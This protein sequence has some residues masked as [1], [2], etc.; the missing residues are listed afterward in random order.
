VSSEAA[1]DR[2]T[3]VV[4]NALRNRSL[5][6]SL[7]AF[8]IFNVAWWANWIAVLVWAYD[9]HG[10][11]GASAVALAQLVPAALLAAPAAAMLGRLPRTRALPLGYLVQTATYLALGAS[12]SLDAPTPVVL[13]TAVLASAA[14]TLTRPVHN[15]MLPEISHTTGDL[16]VGNAAS[17]TLEAAAIVIGPLTCGL[18][19]DMWGSGGV[20]LLM[21]AAT[22]VAVAAT[23]PLARDIQAPV[24][25]VPSTQSA[26]ARVRLV[27]EDPAARVLSTLLAA[28]ST[29][30]GMIDI[31]VVVLALDLLAL[32]DSGPGVLNAAIGLGGL[33]GAAF[34][35]VLVGS[36]RLAVGLALGGLGAGIPF[37]LAGTAPA[38]GMAA[39]LLFLCGAGKAFFEVTARTLLQR[40]LPDRLLCAVFGL[41]ESII[42]AG[43]A[44]GSL[45]APLL[46]AGLGPR[47]AFAAAG[48]F[49]PAVTIVSWASLRK[50]DARA[51]VPPDV[52]ALLM[53]VPIIS[54][55]APRI[56]ERMAREAVEVAAPEGAQ[57]IVE[58]DAGDRFYVIAEGGVTV[59]RGGHTLRQLG[60]GDWFGELALLR[61]VPRTASVVSTSDVS[62]WA[63]ERNHF[64]AAVAYSPQ[65]VQTAD[66]HARERYH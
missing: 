49:L 53:R 47:G 27:V 2:R 11:R 31:L 37:V 64:L 50:L 52:L 36:Q 43:Y 25:A 45:A 29:L 63:L 20:V 19:I 42:M 7:V 15:S 38:A 40:L 23:V 8:L 61:D 33:L 44:L 22:A 12:L 56:V 41:Q 1:P 21:A 60:A 17:G 58:G 35:F 55:L 46:V 39:A 51:A 6:R 54:V 13:A 3:A 9:W 30:I 5:R 66:E 28:E 16:T 24:T 32:S 26:R 14:V 48:L 34:T 62:M 59:S 57:V 18:T 4:R 65:A 10:V